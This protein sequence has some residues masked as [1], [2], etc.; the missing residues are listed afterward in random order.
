MEKKAMGTTTNLE[1]QFKGKTNNELIQMMLD[2]INQG[3]RMFF[4]AAC[5]AKHLITKGVDLSDAICGSMLHLLLRIANGNM[6]PE[7]AEKYLYSGPILSKLSSLPID[8]QRKI[9][10]GPVEIVVYK[11]GT[12]D[13]R[14][15]DFD[16]IIHLKDTCKQL[17][18][19]DGIRSA[20]E[21]IAYLDD[22][23]NKEHLKATI[24]TNLQCETGVEII[25]KGT[26]NI[27][28][29]VKGVFIPAKDL[30]EYATKCFQ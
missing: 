11:N 29:S 25:K 1:V 19:P 21:Q 20:K 17:F 7:L 24:A 30:L 15:L 28:I 4:Q 18:G 22:R 8:D 10:D 3:K 27:G 23:A 26:K 9:L 5:I 16:D 14:K 2:D 6:L 13:I 12:T